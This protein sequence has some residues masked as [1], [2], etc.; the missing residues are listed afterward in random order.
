MIGTLLQRAIFLLS[1]T[2]A[3]IS[4]AL[5]QV[6][7]DAGSSSSAV[8]AELSMDVIP[9]IEALNQGGDS[10][11]S[12]EDLF[13]ADLD[14]DELRKTES[15]IKSEDEEKKRNLVVEGIVQR[16]LG[17]NQQQA[18]EAEL[19]LLELAKPADLATLTQPLQNEKT[20]MAARVALVETLGNLKTKAVIRP[21][22]FELQHGD[23]P[24]QVAALQALGALG[25]PDVI[26]IL[27]EALFSARSTK[28]QMTAAAALGKIRS[29]QAIPPLEKALRESPSSLVKKVITLSL[30]R[31]RGQLR[32]D[33]ISP[34]PNGRALLLN[35]KGLMYYYYAPGL[36]LPN[37]P[38]PRLLVCV[39]DTKY[40]IE[41]LFK[42]CF[43]RAKQLQIALLVPF[44]DPLSFP[45]YG[46]F[47]LR[48][49][50]T[51]KLFWE[52][53]AHVTKASTLETRELFLFGMGEGGAFVSRLATAYPARVGRATFVTTNPI[54][55]D[56]N[57]FFP[58][59]IKRSPRAPDLEFDPFQIMKSEL[60]ILMGPAGEYQRS[61][62]LLD[63]IYGYA[64]K[65]GSIPRAGVRRIKVPDDI[66]FATQLGIRVLFSSN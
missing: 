4:P 9:S 20:P 3:L 37:S 31:L 35:Y 17:T 40:N 29:R 33:T 28:Q 30:A 61:K 1:F 27:S 48:G 41:K 49:R 65:Y 63:Y 39:H 12:D 34:V 7:S 52:L 14:S 53:I 22:R 5:G 51:D 13:P 32:D 18:L 23:E 46:T 47:N 44:F 56:A 25:N 62:A 45:E 54:L 36:R 6:G 24:V 19:A 58:D 64:Q 8:D 50:R 55:L 26:P 2:L 66:E 59:G 38:N 16:L 21:L 15:E 57:R 43:A 42:E 60:T 11:L 10:S